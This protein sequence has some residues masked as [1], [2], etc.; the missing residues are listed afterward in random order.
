MITE[1]HAVQPTELH[2]LQAHELAAVSGGQISYAGA[3]CTAGYIGYTDARGATV[4]LGA[5]S[6]CKSN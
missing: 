6:V 3:T 5:Y 1:D 4:Y 2:E